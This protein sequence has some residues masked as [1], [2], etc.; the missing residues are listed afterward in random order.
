M[1]PIW[2]HQAEWMDR[3]PRW[4]VEF[5]LRVRIV[6]PA[7][8]WRWADTDRMD[9]RRSASRSSDGSHGGGGRLPL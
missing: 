4:R 1:S 6:H 8:R 7:R 3:E 5:T 2:R 9:D